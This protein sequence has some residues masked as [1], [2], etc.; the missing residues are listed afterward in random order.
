MSVTYTT[1]GERP[2]MVESLDWQAHWERLAKAGAPVDELT[3]WLLR[4]QYIKYISPA[5]AEKAIR[6]ALEPED[7][8]LFVTGRS[9]S[10]KTILIH[11][12]QHLFLKRRPVLEHV[13][14]YADLS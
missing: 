6:W 10:G 1:P 14:D 4:H 11:A 12:I 3:A 9:C 2:R 5:D 7:K 8:N 13:L